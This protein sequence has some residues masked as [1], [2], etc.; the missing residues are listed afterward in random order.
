MAVDIV[1]TLDDR[2]GTITTGGAAQTIAAAKPYRR[3][4]IV[5]NISGGDLWANFGIP[6]VANQPSLRIPPGGAME[7]ST[8]LGVIPSAYVS[9]IGATTGQAFVAKEA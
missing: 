9:L 7:F 2:S 8:L 1:G 4:L 6:A 3:Y 5:E